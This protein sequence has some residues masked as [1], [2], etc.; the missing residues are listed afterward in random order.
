[1]KPNT[2]FGFLAV[3]VVVVV[4]AGF[5]ITSR[6]GSAAVD[7]DSERMFP[8]LT[9]AINEVSEISVQDKEKTLKV[10]RDGDK[11][12][13]PDRNNYVASDEIVRDILVGLSEL[14]V[15][16]AKTK[17]PSLYSRL[18][19]ED[20]SAKDAKS[21]LLKVKGK[22]GKLL[23]DVIVG[24]INAEIAGPTETG[25]Y[26]RKTGDEQSWLVSGKLVVPDGVDKLVQ[27]QFMDVESSRI[28]T[29]VVTQPDGKFM[30]VKR[31]KPE[32]TKF[33]LLNLPEG[34]AIEYQSDIDNMGDG[35]DKLDLED[36]HA[37]ATLKFPAD[38][39]IKTEIRTYD[40]LIVNVEMFEDEKAEVFWGKFK[41]SV[42]DD[43]AKK[44]E[45][46][47]EAAKINA[48]VANWAYQLPAYKYRYMSRKFSD[49]LKK[50][51]D[52]KKK[53]EK[54]KDEKK[55]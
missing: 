3:T 49:V 17:K 11:W 9:T 36:V 25:R 16:E 42:A 33:K 29:V 48:V 30:S 8:A 7:Q 21:V 31:E 6:Y 52:K 45:V 39:T 26:L 32:D 20:L 15:R 4:A 22:D 24:K 1:M 50:P 51:E 47:K 37:A 18:Q 41:A 55:K 23:V 53:D 46:T 38:K 14:R 19:V 35:L 34:R 2:F 12:V 10:A 54:K 28:D 44:D 27:P 5:S 13:L 43:A 40:G